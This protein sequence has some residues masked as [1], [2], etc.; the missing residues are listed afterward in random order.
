MAPI[1]KKMSVNGLR[2]YDNI[3]LNSCDLI[4]SSIDYHDVENDSLTVEWEL[5][6]ENWYYYFGAKETKPK[7]YITSFTKINDS[8]V[9]FE[10]PSEEGPYR[11]FSYVYDNQGNFATANVPFY[12]LESDK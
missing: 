5:F 4:R 9:E 7:K 6:P 8:L 10:V 12:V 1:L 11:L 2:P 3:I